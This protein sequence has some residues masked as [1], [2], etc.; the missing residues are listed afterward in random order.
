MLYDNAVFTYD[1]ITMTTKKNVLMS[2]IHS[3]LVVFYT[4]AI[5]LILSNGEKLFGGED[6]FLTPL[7]FLML[8]VLSASIVGALV[9]GRPILLYIDGKKHEALSFFF[10]TI[11]WLMLLTLVVVLIGIYIRK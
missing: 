6:T 3:V 2:F 5:S 8:F 10:G 4:A 11:G 1:I 9:L 7:I